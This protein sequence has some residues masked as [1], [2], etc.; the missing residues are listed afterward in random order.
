MAAIY[1][2]Q[3][4]KVTDDDL[5]RI[6]GIPQHEED[7]MDAAAKDLAGRE[8]G[9]AQQTKGGANSAPSLNDAEQ[10]A[11][12][13]FAP[14]LM[15]GGKGAPTKMQARGFRRLGNKKFLIPVSGLT[16]IIII[17]VGFLLP[18]HLNTF[19]NFYQGRAFRTVMSNLDEASDKMFEQ[20]L[21]NHVLRNLGPACPTTRQTTTCVPRLPGN[22]PFSRAFNAMSGANVPGKL[23]SPPLNIVFG[24]DITG[25]YYMVAPDLPGG[26]LDIT[27]FVEGRRSFYD[28]EEVRRLDIRLKI[29][30]QLAS[31]TLYR[32][33]FLRFQMRGLL[34]EYGIVRC[35]VACTFRENRQDRAEQRRNAYKSW[36]YQRV[37]DPFNTGMGDAIDCMFNRQCHPDRIADFNGPGG[38]ARTEFEVQLHQRRQ[39]LSR[40]YPS[41]RL[42]AIERRALEVFRAGSFSNLVLQRLLGKVGAKAAAASVPVVGWVDTSAL[43]VDA[44]ATAGPKIAV[45]KYALASTAAMSMA[46]MFLTANDENRLG[47][48]GA[49]ELGGFDEALTTASVDENGNRSNA[50]AT[51]LYQDYM[52]KPSGNVAFM[53]LLFPSASA[54]STGTEGLQQYRCNDGNPTPS[55][56][57]VCHEEMFAM[58]PGLIGTVSNAIPDVL[59]TAASFYNSTVGAVFD[60]VLQPLQLLTKLPGYSSVEQFIAGLTDPIVSAFQDYIFPVAVSNAMSGGRSGNVIAGGLTKLGNDMAHFLIGGMA[61]SPQQS[62]AL[63][64][65]A[66]AEE[67][68]AFKNL[69]L[70]ERL[71]DK[72]NPRS[73]VSQITLT[74]PGGA[75]TKARN[76]VSS[77]ANLL[78]NPF[79]SL[80]QGFVGLFSARSANAAIFPGNAWGDTDYG[81]PVDDPIFDQDLQ[82][83]WN[84]HCTTNAQTEAWHQASTFTINE[85]TGQPTNTTTNPCM[86]IQAIGESMSA[87]YEG[88]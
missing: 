27:D 74:M 73:L 46:T 36:L 80:T 58:D 81:Y 56:M 51:P 32:R 55:G 13:G 44:L 7:Q 69:P 83:Y 19:L 47:L 85:K 10:A 16:I 28:Y 67:T 40:I 38:A 1:D 26:E 63:Q 12:G 49:E 53:D 25:R 9:A 43:V 18:S 79:G 48:L 33:A 6:T 86:L 20:Y 4:E 54:Q 30:E 14:S 42:E 31:L 11:P 70:A 72:E 39:E 75:Q 24:R 82:V 29:R 62:A 8:A 22:D 3:K 65:K 87:M 57:Q 88:I 71:F 34:R 66:I 84:Q 15:G 77:F 21:R 37:L 2:D 60:F 50:E 76:S 68:A 64:E 17:V 61:L 41:E 35:L 59:A 78:T 23:A 5:R 45:M 52:S